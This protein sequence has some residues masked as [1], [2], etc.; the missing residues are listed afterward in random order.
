MGE[1]LRPAPSL[2][3][4]QTYQCLSGR[5]GEVPI[6]QVYLDETGTLRHKGPQLKGGAGHNPKEECGGSVNIVTKR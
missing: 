6:D 5:C 2:E 4:G 3:Y 1:E